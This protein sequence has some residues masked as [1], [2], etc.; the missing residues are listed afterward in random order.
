LLGV[1][2]FRGV[3][4]PDW[5][6]VLPDGP[7]RP[8]WRPAEYTQPGRPDDPRSKIRRGRFFAPVPVRT[9]PR[10]TVPGDTAHAV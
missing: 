6:A 10:S 1:K 7:D 8:L 3:G 9:G 2:A 5:P 4:R